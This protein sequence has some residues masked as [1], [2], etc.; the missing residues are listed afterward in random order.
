[1]GAPNSEVGYTSATT[2]RETTKSIR[3][4][5]WHWIKKIAHIVFTCLVF[6]LEHIEN[7]APHNINWSVF[8]TQMKSVYCV[9]RTGSL[10]KEVCD[11]SLKD[12]FESS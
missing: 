2:R 5:W 8:I 7:F 12:W 3:H 1:M 11:S 4:I 6:I 10:N 9:V